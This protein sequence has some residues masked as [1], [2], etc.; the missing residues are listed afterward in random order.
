MEREFILFKPDAVQRGLIGDL[1]KRIEAKGLRLVAMKFMNVS[2]E[3][4]Q[5]HYAV[6]KERPFF[7]GLVEFITSGPVVA[8][9]VEGNNA[10]SVTR[11]IVGGTNPAEAAPGTIRGDL[12]MD[13]GRNLIH[14]SDSVENAE[15]ELG[16]YFS[17]EEYVS[18]KPVTETWLYE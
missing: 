17:D 12:G 13:I 9:A 2:E 16:L 3:L 7:N 8:L 14:A 10:V 18:W 5:K 6:H 11:T 15:Y 1:L 4:A